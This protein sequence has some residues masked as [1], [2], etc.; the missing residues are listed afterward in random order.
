[1]IQYR[2]VKESHYHEELGQ[3]TAFG[4]CAYRIGR[5]ETEALV[6][7]S[8][9]FLSAHDAECFA[10]RCNRLSLDPIHLLDVIADT[11]GV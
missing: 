6:R 3:Y 4:I 5:S 1:M 8:D 7:V 2:P 11:L 10:D 9:V